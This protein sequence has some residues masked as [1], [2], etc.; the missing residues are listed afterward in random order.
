MVLCKQ[1]F[2]LPQESLRG[3]AAGRWQGM[4]GR[5][6]RLSLGGDGARSQ[7]GPTPKGAGHRI[8]AA[9]EHMKDDR[10]EEA[11]FKAG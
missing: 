2:H 1:G 9:F 11:L 10:A 5:P 6:R 7:G 3:G 8:F 4:S